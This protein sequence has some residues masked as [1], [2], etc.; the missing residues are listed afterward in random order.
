MIYKIEGTD[1]A[2]IQKARFMFEYE[3]MSQSL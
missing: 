3:I 1:T 2:K